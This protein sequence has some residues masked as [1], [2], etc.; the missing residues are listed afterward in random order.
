MKERSERHRERRQGSE[1][2]GEL[3]TAKAEDVEFSAEQADEEDR[4][5]QRR[6]AEADRRAA[7]CEGE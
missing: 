3:P 1:S 4:I 7:D 5:A 2:A 6:A